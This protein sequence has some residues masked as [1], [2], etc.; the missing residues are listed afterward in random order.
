MVFAESLM[1]LLATTGGAAVV[2]SAPGRSGRA[3]A[4]R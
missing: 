4:S 3:R 1:H 2:R